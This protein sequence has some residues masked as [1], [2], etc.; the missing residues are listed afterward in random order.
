MWS[1]A[2][3][4]QPERKAGFP[5]QGIKEEVKAGGSAQGLNRVL[6]TVFTAPDDDE[7]GEGHARKGKQFRPKRFDRAKRG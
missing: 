4:A 7:N 2:L 3:R 1:D 5:A 6:G